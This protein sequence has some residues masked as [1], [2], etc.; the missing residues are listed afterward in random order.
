MSRSRLL[1]FLLVCASASAADWYVPTVVSPAD[2]D[3]PK[4]QTSVRVYNP[5]SSAADVDVYQIGAI[6][7]PAPAPK[8]F[9]IGSG[10]A[11]GVDDLLGQAFGASGQSGAVRLRAG[12]GLGVSGWRRTRRRPAGLRE[13]SRQAWTS[14]TGCKGATDPT[15]YGQP[16][17]R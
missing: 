4:T 12:Q 17:P 9:T 8:R 5:N 2:S 7:G 3:D 14:G 15:R 16:H 1:S 13:P 6:G 10:Q 11:L